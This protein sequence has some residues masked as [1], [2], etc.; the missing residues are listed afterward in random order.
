MTR[1]VLPLA[2]FAVFTCDSH[3]PT[4]RNGASAGAVHAAAA[5]LFTQHYAQSRFAAWHVRGNAAGS[6]CAVLLVNVSIIL[7]DSMVEAMHYGAGTYEAY[8][9][10]V[11]RFARERDFRAVAYRDSSGRYWTYGPL[12]TTDAETLVPCR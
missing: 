6:D 7:D 5:N 10:G 12:S 9:G 2:L 8:P 11:R 4:P 3:G 1:Y